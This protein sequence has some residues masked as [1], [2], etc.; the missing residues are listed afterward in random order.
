[1]CIRDRYQRRVH[2]AIILRIG[3]KCRSFDSQHRK[4]DYSYSP[5]NKLLKIKNTDS[6]NFHNRNLFMIRRERDNSICFLVKLYIYKTAFKKPEKA[7]EKKKKKKKKKKT[8]P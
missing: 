4:K 5:S 6:L 3:I 2:G 1:M 7:L 8:P